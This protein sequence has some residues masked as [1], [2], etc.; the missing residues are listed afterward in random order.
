MRITS[1][2]DIQKPNLEI[3]GQTI[4]D[5]KIGYNSGENQN[6]LETIYLLSETDDEGFISYQI[7]NIMRMEIE[8]PNC[9]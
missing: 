2:E 6:I 7:S 5:S 3:N 8:K 4:V 1:I 9:F